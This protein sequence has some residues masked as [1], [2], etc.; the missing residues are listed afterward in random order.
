MQN[1]IALEVLTSVSGNGFSLDE[2]VIATRRLFEQ[3]GMPGLI[4]L[5]LRLLDE[6][7]SLRLRQNNSD[8]KPT[9]CCAQPDYEFQ[10]WQERRFR[11]SAGEVQIHWRRLRCRT[12]GKS[13]LPLREFLGLEAYQSKTAELEKT[14]M[15]VVSEQSYRRS[16]QHLETIVHIPVPKS[17]AHRWVVESTCDQ[18]DTG[19]ETFDQL[20]ADGTG[21]KKR[22]NKDVGTSN[23]GELRIAL[24]V[25]KQGFVVPLGSW[26]GES[27]DEIAQEIQGKRQ[28]NQPVAEV[29]VSD[30]ERGLSEALADLCNEHQRCSWHFIHDLNFTMWQ[31]G[32][33][34][35]E[36]D[37]KR[38]ELI[39]II[40]IELPEEDFQAVKSQ[41][42]E[43]ILSKLD[44]AR[45]DLEQ[46]Y[47]YLIS[48]G[49]DE[50]AG[51]VNR[52]GKNIFTYLER[53]LKTGLITPRVSSMIE[54]MMR[55]I[56]R[57]LKRIA[58]GWS[59]AGAAKMARIII[60]RFTSAAQWGEY[61][62]KRLKI[63]G[64]IL[65]LLRDV[66]VVSPQPLGR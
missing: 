61:W 30:G 60:K 7:L 12:C 41:E 57:R 3:E 5:V 53:W 39:N 13:T 29:L 62:K 28:D 4:G 37:D 19:T 14:V 24:G 38:Q 23:R 65:M 64:K 63:H 47:N 15:E 31:D 20:F 43:E 45:N 51:Y 22:C 21:Y 40:G 33:P 35:T 26:S 10:D 59:P 46:L 25:D 49:Y 55:E 8:W 6:N 34:K 58:F 1:I 42:R 56:A 44:K 11:T 27:W 50:A 2:L 48:Q 17:T 66:R 18:I 36:R 32:S 16:S 9:S 52:G 54:R